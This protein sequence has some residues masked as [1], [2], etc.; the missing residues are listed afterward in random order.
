MS[1]AQIALAKEMVPPPWFELKSEP[2]RDTWHGGEKRLPVVLIGGIFWET[3]PSSSRQGTLWN[4]AN[5]VTLVSRSTASLTDIPELLPSLSQAE[6]RSTSV[7]EA[8]AIE[9]VF[10][11]RRLTGF[12]WTQLADLLKVDRR[13]LHNWVK[14]GEVRRANRQHI[15]K[16]L[17]VLRFA[18]RGSAEEN[19][20][21]VAEVSSAGGTVFE[22]IKAGRH[23]NA[24]QYLSFGRSESIPAPSVS[25]QGSWTGEFQPMAT[26]AEAIGIEAIES[27]PDEPRPASRRRR[28]KRG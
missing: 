18:D 6:R 24:R 16:T 3:R 15:A 7:N 13:T 10:E 22:A 19:A 28:I 26:H 23:D 9:N 4:W 11:L 25:N 1:E 12:N 8:D 17:S 2:T 5:F 20:R 21:A 14:G 27:L